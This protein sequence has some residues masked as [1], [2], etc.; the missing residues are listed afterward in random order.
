MVVSEE[1]SRGDRS[2]RR[3]RGRVSKNDFKVIDKNV[4]EN[5]AQLL[6]SK[7]FMEINN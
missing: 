5:H 7:P 4:A 2:K 1:E 3:G 6:L